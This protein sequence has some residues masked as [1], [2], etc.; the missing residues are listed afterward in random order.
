MKGLLRDYEF[1]SYADVTPAF[2][3]SIGCRFLI[4]D[5]DNTLAPYEQPLPDEGNLAWLGS[6]S[7]AG[8]SVAL[9]SNNGRERVELFSRGLGIPAFWDC[10]KPSRRFIRTAMEA[11]GADPASTVYLGDQIFTDVYAAK[12]SGIRAIKLPP[13]RDKKTLFFRIKR[14]LERPV[15]RRYR[16][17]H[18]A[19]I[20]GGTDGPEVTG[21]REGSGGA[22]S[23]DGKCD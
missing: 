6:L 20:P 10:R 17:L 1:G 13:I 11:L 23:R 16:R 19:G 7:G 15:M 21:G 14:L 2:L 9:V 22:D 12:R 18:G 3:G 5:I 4:A 8:I